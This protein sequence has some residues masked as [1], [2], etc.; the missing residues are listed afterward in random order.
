LAERGLRGCD[1]ALATIAYPV[2][3]NDWA[4]IKPSESLR[5]EIIFVLDLIPDGSIP[6]G[7]TKHIDCGNAHGL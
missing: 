4:A 5:E 3:K 1:V 6:I 2:K 7:G